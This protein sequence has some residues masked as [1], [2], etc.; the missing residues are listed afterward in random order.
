[1]Q[2]ETVKAEI[3]AVLSLG[4]CYVAYYR[5]LNAMGIDNADFRTIDTY[6]EELSDARKKAE[7]VIKKARRD[8]DDE[9]VEE[10]RTQEL[11]AEK[12]EK[13]ENERLITELRAKTNAEIDK[14]ITALRNSSND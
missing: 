12:K 9:Q 4:N 11:A 10:A 6:A 2:L 5:L 13:A 7:E 8:F 14:K 3:D 1:M